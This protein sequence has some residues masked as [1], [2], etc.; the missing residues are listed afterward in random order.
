MDNNS[1]E[2][3]QRTPEERRKDV[4]DASIRDYLARYREAYNQVDNDTILLIRDIG[5]QV[6]S[7]NDEQLKSQ[8]AKLDNDIPSDDLLALDER[9][10]LGSLTDAYKLDKDPSYTDSGKTPEEREEFAVNVLRKRVAVRL[11]NLSYLKDPHQNG[12]YKEVYKSEPF[13]QGH[14]LLVS[15]LK[16]AH[17]TLHPP[18][19]PPPTVQ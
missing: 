9:E 5:L 14:G 19:T 2:L 15:L 1:P 16:E 12:T 18:Q 7:Y 11:F 6:L 4:L 13:K 10:R 17:N 3:P 8:A